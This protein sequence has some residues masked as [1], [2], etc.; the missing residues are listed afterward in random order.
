MEQQAREALQEQQLSSQDIKFYEDWYSESEERRDWL[1]RPAHFS[2]KLEK[3]TYTGKDALST[4]R[5]KSTMALH[6]VVVS[7]KIAVAKEGRARKL[8]LFHRR[9]ELLFYEDLKL[10]VD[11]RTLAEKLQK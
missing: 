5:Q 8:R 2:A 11:H 4:Y 7:K 3:N 9:V 10:G 6:N 1:A